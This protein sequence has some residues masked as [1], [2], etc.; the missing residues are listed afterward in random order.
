MKQQEE[1][2]AMRSIKRLSNG[3]SREMCAAFGSGMFSGAQGRT[4]H[5][6]LAEHTKSD[7]FQKDIEAEFGLRPPTATALLKE[8]EQ[9]GLIRKEPVSYDA[10]RKKIVVT[11]KAL[12][13]KDCVL[14]GLD[15]L[16]QKL[17]A[18]ISEEEMQ[19]FFSVTDKMLKNLAE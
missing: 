12:K 16:N 10:R 8:L 17:I 13:Y 18:G 7:V 4:L 5:F 14:K 15:K 9:R 19:V 1:K 6:L 11:E 3:I 2:I